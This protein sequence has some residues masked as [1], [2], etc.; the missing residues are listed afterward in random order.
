MGPLKQGADQVIPAAV[1]GFWIL[2][3]R[4]LEGNFHTEQKVG[5]GDISKRKVQ[6]S[7]EMPNAEYYRLKARDY[8]EKARQAETQKAAEKLRE[9]GRECA[10]MAVMIEMVE[11]KPQDN[12]GGSN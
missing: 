9:R 3:W 8:Y 12:S 6:W 5:P 11:G 7:E 4:H 10:Q 1:S 2:A